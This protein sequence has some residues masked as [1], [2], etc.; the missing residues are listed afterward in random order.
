MEA[1]QTVQ[2]DFIFK[3]YWHLQLDIQTSSLILKR[4]LS[5]GIIANLDLVNELKSVSAGVSQHTQPRVST[6]KPVEICADLA[7]SWEKLRQADTVYRS[8]FFSPDFARAVGAVRE[9]ARIGVFERDGR[10]VGILPFQSL[11]RSTLA[12]IGGAYNDLHGILGDLGA[13]TCFASLVNELGGSSF[14]FHSIVDNASASVQRFVFGT[15]EAFLANLRIHPESYVTFLENTRETIYK[16]RKKSRKMVKDLGP[17]RLEYDCHDHQ[18]LDKV[19]ELKRTQYQRT[20]IFDLLSVPWAKRLLHT[21]LER[22][23]E[24]CRGIL[25]VLYA[26]DRLIAGHY[27]MVEDQM[28]HYWF[29]VYDFQYHQYSPG[30]ALFLEISR[31]AEK[32]GIEKIDFGYG[33]QPYKQKLTD[34][35]SKVLFGRVDSSP[36]R[37]WR[38]RC[39]TWI[40][41]RRS[42]LPFKKSMKPLIRRL[43]PNLDRSQYQ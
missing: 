24:K 19:I 41:D 35:V 8:P 28:L 34:T 12:P 38:D 18:V 1:S 20:Y 33:A 31:E 21:L 39:S 23:E 43:L 13:P 5:Q 37:W 15:T 17:I 6:V 10:C 3:K 11:N 36:I 14:R 25:S 22:R 29:P 16:Q 7:A 4:R 40:N 2:T 27:G 26:G 30:T 9:D 32:A 42:S